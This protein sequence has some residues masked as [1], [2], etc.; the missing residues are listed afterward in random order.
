MCP[1][2]HTQT[3][4]GTIWYC[5]LMCSL[6]QTGP[7]CIPQRKLNINC[8]PIKRTSFLSDAE[9]TEQCCSFFPALHQV[10]QEEVLICPSH[11][12][13][14]ANYCDLK[15][16][17]AGICGDARCYCTNPPVPSVVF[18]TLSRL[19]S[20][21]GAEET[22]RSGIR[23]DAA[24]AVGP[25]Y[26]YVHECAYGCAQLHF[27]VWLFHPSPTCPSTNCLLRQP[28]TS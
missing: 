9:Q 17:L 25:A 10:T 18:R 4:K 5:R 28:Q 16:A 1:V 27:S 21:I 6:K 14:P 8:V 26:L 7:F 3:S 20:F 15:C 12:A 19:A 23:C 2:H 13:V 11:A 24:G 22:H